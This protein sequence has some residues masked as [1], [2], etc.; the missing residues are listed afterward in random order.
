MLFVWVLVVLG[1]GVLLKC[2]IKY[3]VMFFGGNILLIRLVL[4]VVVGMF[5]WLVDCG[6][7]VMMK[8][9]EVLRLIRL[10]VLF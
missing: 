4:I 6:C 1:W 10:L 9:L 7:W 3:W 5:C 2:W 8:L